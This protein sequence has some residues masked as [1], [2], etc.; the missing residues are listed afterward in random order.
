MWNGQQATEGHHLHRP[1]HQSI[2]CFLPAYCLHLA[3]CLRACH[4]SPKTGK[5]ASDRCVS[6]DTFQS[7]SEWYVLTR[8]GSGVD[9]GANLTGV[10]QALHSEM[11]A[12]FGKCLMPVNN[13]N[14]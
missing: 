3:L 7:S 5:V 8:C 13:S 12:T 9:I 4:G 10:Y 2:I 11:H 14:R 1:P 6:L